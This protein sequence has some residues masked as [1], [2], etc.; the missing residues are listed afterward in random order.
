MF[1]DFWLTL[2]IA[3]IKCFYY[4]TS[5][6]GSGKFKLFLKMGTNIN[7]M[8]RKKMTALLL[9][10]LIGKKSEFAKIRY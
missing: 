1:L 9:K 4:N 5:S 10:L 2:S 8:T 7:K 6:G 3:D